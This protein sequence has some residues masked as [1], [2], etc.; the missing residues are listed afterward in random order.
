MATLKILESGIEVDSDEF[1]KLLEWRDD[2]RKSFR[3][4]LIEHF[5]SNESINTYSIEMYN[6]LIIW[7]KTHFDFKPLI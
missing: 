6:D 2:N 1:Y 4:F 5:L 3:E 7:S